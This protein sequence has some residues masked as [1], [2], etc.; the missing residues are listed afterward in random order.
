MAKGPALGSA[1]RRA[2]EEWVVQGFPRDRDSLA[3][4]ADAAA[5]ATAS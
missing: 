2:E 4:I 1:L 5:R 3:R